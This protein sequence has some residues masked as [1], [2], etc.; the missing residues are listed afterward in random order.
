MSRLPRLTGGKV[1]NALGR[2]LAS[3][4]AESKAAIIVCATLTAESQWSQCMGPK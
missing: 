3:L 1:I 4:S 2:R